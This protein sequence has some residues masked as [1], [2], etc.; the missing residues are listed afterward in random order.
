MDISKTWMSILK[1]SLI[2][3]MEVMNSLRG[4]DSPLCDLISFGVVYLN[5]LR[6][7][8][9]NI[10]VEVVYDCEAKWCRKSLA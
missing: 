4:I 10:S 6:G 3:V 9:L 8:H 1:L 5:S 2:L 7:E